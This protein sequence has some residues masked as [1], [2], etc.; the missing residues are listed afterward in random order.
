MED[1]SQQNPIDPEEETPAQRL[2]RILAASQRKGQGLPQEPAERRPLEEPT[3]ESAVQP[4]SLPT[5]DAVPAERTEAAGRTISGD[6]QRI[7]IPEEPDAQPSAWDE[8]LDNA[9]DLLKDAV[10]RAANWIG[11]IQLPRLGSGGRGHRKPPRS[12]GTGKSGC[13]VRGLVILA[14]SFVIVTILGLSFILIQYFTIAAGLPSVEDLRQYAS[15]FETTRIY[16]RNGNLIYEILDPNA[17]RRTYTTLDDVSPFLIA[18]TIATEDKDFYTNPGF[19]PLGIVRA[20]WQ[21]YT[22][23]E[24]VSGA[25]TITQQLARTLLLSPEERNQI[26][27]QRK[28]REIV[29][30]A[31]ITRRY[32]KDEILELYLNEI[33][34]GNLAYGI[35]AAA[36]T[37]FSTTAGQL[38][39][40]EASFL[41]GLPQAPA[42]YDVYTNRDAAELRQSDVLG[43]M[44]Q[45]SSERNCIRVNQS[46]VPICVTLNE[47]VAAAQEIDNTVFEYH[48]INMPYPHWVNYIRTQLEAQYDPQTIYRSG[49]RVYTTL[50]P[51]LQD[52]AQASLTEQ[53]DA[54]AANNATDGALVAIQPSSGQILAMVGSADFFSEAIS[55][56]VNMAIAP[57]QPGSSI[58]PLTYT[59]AFEKGWTPATLIW[60]VASEFPPSGDPD[61]TRDPYK[62]VNYDGKYHGPVLARTALAN[63]YNI[64]AV[65]TLNFVGIYDDPATTEKEGFIAFAERMGIT[66]LTRDDYGLSLTL[67]GGDV[68]LL[69]LTGAYAVFAN[70][71]QRMAPYSIERIEDHS[72]NIV[73]QHETPAAEQT[74]SRDHAYLISNILSDN[75]ARTPAFGSN[76]V[77]KLPFSAAVKTGTTNDFRDNWTLGYT[78]DIA[79]GVWI[80]NADYTPMSNISGVTGAAPLWANVMQWAVGYYWGGSPSEFVQP[81]TV[82]R[83]TI[84]AASGASP[85]SNCPSETKEL[86]ADGQ[87][88]LDKKDDL[89]KDVEVDTWTNLKASSACSEYVEEKKTVNVSDPWAI[90]WL[91]GNDAGKTWAKDMGF[92]SPLVFTPQEECSGDSPRPTIIFVGLDE[93]GDIS[94]PYVDIYAVVNATKNFKE[95]KLQ[96]GVG[97]NPTKWKTLMS[98][99][100]QY[101][102]PKHLISWDVYEADATRITLRIYMESTKGTFAEKRIHLNLLVPT[103]TPTMTVIPTLTPI[104]PTAEPIIATETPELVPT[105]TPFGGSDG[106]EATP[107]P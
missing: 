70:Q 58:K 104:P 71:G 59:A 69:E 62:P 44:V 22:S 91:T 52:Y 29:L 78:P 63:S 32:S 95:F 28:A 15:Q 93:D 102:Q 25:S 82:Q 101:D 11:S 40:A 61:D 7:P 94:T 83:Q 99:T 14:F 68:S 79:I 43:L 13:L 27:T 26:T 103:L 31:E 97:N 72:G 23:G 9:S 86:F 77:L 16:D 2:R 46:N 48:N 37:Y 18:A 67:G 85:S 21:N 8:F 41:A 80:G 54:L 1:N 106:D 60:D 56:Q 89:W 65:K 81:D 38:N 30:A 35:E 64:P 19:D 66:T 5:N 20:F 92:S 4:A 105:N 96:Y 49:F 17:G 51:T 84:C 34:Y 75:Q 88:P 100:E 45:F 53:V 55:G 74:I 10:D 73:Y 57:R 39:L 90:K 33:Y 76:S 47:A 98:S 12:S 6:T 107:A 24:V 87:P 36:E 42:V 3:R 50:D